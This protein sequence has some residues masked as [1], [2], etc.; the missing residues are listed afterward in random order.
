MVTVE[1]E[2]GANDLDR[3]WGAESE[4]LEIH[5]SLLSK[6]YFFLYV[7]ISALFS[8]CTYTSIKILLDSVPTPVPGENIKFSQ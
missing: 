6:L 8:V 1:E 3:A 4:V 2:W 5:F 7:L